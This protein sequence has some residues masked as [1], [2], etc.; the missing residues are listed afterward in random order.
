MNSEVV[1]QNVTYE[2]RR[3]F[4]SDQTVAQRLQEIISKREIPAD[5]LTA[6]MRSQY[7]MGSGSVREKEVIN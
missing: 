5:S 7:N 1:I 3:S 2:I 6:Q 4:I